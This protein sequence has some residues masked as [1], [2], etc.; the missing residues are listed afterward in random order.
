MILSK[1]ISDTQRTALLDDTFDWIWLNSHLW[2]R[3][4]CLH[5]RMILSKGQTVPVGKVFS[6]FFPTFFLKFLSSA[7]TALSN[8]EKCWFCSMENHFST[9]GIPLRA[10]KYS[11]IPSFPSFLSKKHLLSPDSN[12]LKAQTPVVSEWWGLV[13]GGHHCQW[14][15]SP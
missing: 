4:C 14:Y 7:L 8:G 15:Y 2:L 5:K 13:A 3:R 9:R 12:R 6:L 10:F 1:G 11:S